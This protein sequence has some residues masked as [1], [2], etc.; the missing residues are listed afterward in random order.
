M[1]SRYRGTEIPTL[2][3]VMLYITYDKDTEPQQ[4]MNVRHHRSNYHTP[5]YKHALVSTESVQIKNT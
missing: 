3:H 5:K 4:R 2:N 1:I